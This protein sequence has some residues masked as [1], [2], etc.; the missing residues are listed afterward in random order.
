MRQ[1]ETVLPPDKIQWKQHIIYSSD[2]LDEDTWREYSHEEKPDKHK[3]R[4]NPENWPVIFKAK[5]VTNSL[6]WRL[7]RYGV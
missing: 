1:I 2:I 4:D 3:L 7:K 6:D 5:E